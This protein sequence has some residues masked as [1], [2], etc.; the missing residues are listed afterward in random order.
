MKRGWVKFLLWGFL[1][2]ASLG[3]FLYAGLKTF[4]SPQKIQAALENKLTAYIGL[5][6]TTRSLELEWF[7]VPSFIA[8]ELR[9]EGPGGTALVEIPSLRL[10]VIPVIF[11]ERK[12]I[13]A[14]IIISE[15][16][17]HFVRDSDG[18]F[19]FD[20]LFRTIKE[21]AKR[22]RESKSLLFKFKRMEI[23]NGDFTF[24]DE[25]V[26]GSYE[27]V[28]DGGVIFMDEDG[29][30]AF[31]VTGRDADQ[32]SPGSYKITGS[33]GSE[34]RIRGEIHDAGISFL[35]PYLKWITPFD[36]KFDGTINCLRSADG[37][38]GWSLDAACGD[39]LLSDQ[40]S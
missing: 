34:T 15:P 31:D 3:V 37:R 9:I 18:N 35:G 1:F 29:G 25:K 10:V 40:K 5:K 20:R 4:F 6:T 24:T 16:R 22:A 14:Q 11:P 33:L 27:I 26:K 12:L 32:K 39:L 36:G 13:V 23:N 21:R 30:A 28:L 2:A 7:P 38:W 8:E 17:I 19:N